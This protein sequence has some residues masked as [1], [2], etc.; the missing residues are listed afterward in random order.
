MKPRWFLRSSAGTNN[1][2][3]QALMYMHLFLVC[4]FRRYLTR[5]L[6]WHKSIF[7]KALKDGIIVILRFAFWERSDVS[8]LMLSTKQENH[9]CHLL[10]SM[11]EAV[12][13]QSF[14]PGP[15]S[16]DAITH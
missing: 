16:L 2:Y 5:E 8:L 14:N 4:L 7:H 13:N 3:E 9:G 15:P 1:W 12:L 6:I 10:T 11:H